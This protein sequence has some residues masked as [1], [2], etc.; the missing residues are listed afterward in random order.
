MQHGQR[1]I[2]GQFGSTFLDGNA[3][4]IDLTAAAA[5]KYIGAITILGTDGA[6]T[7]TFAILE[8]ADGANL[9]NASISTV[10]GEDEIAT[11]WGAVTDDGS[12]FA[13]I[14]TTSHEFPA[15]VTIYGRWDKVEMETGSCICYMY[16]KDDRIGL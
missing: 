4:L 13:K 11:P 10:D 3:S 7:S 2:L 8:N 6:A 9:G 1:Y 15:G 12:N 16:P 14:L 5:T